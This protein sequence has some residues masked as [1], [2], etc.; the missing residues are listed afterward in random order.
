MENLQRLKEENMEL[1]KA[2]AV[3]MNNLFIKKLLEALEKVSRGEYVS[4]EEFFSDSP[5]EDA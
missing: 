2:L 4:E 3:C 5:Q 1:K